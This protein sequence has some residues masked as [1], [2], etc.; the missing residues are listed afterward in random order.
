MAKK[1]IIVCDRCGEPAD[2][3]RVVVTVGKQRSS[4]DLCPAHLTEL[5]DVVGMKK[6]PKARRRRRSEDNATVRAWA[7]ENGY[8]V[9]TRGKVPAA[10]LE[11]Y[12]AA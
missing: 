8:E 3:G 1:T 7:A 9:S 6:P 4:A 11:A 5:L 12:R 2:A 10:V